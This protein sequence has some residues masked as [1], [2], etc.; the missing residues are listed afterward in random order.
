VFLTFSSSA[1]DNSDDK[2]KRVKASVKWLSASSAE[3]SAGTGRWG[4]AQLRHYTV[5]WREWGEGPHVVLV[6]GLAGGMELLGPVARVLS[7]RF[8]VI[9]YQLRGEDDCFA[10]RRRFDLHDLVED[11]DQF[12]EWHCLERPALFGVSFGG[13]LALEYAARYGSSLSGLAVQGAG[14]WFERGLLQRLAGMV[15]ARYPLP[16]DNPFVNQFFNL[17]F[18]GPQQPGPLFEFVTRQCWQTDQSVMAH[19]FKLVE[20][21][22]I[23]DRLERI[24]VPTL[25]LVG[26][27]DVLVSQRSLSAL[28]E[29]LPH[30]EVV[31]L[32]GA[33]HLAFV[34]QPGRVADEVGR[35]LNTAC[36]LQNAG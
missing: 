26:D 27:K 3:F 29:G 11:L 1:S 28:A 35:F 18:G 31:R 2:E 36:S 32:K 6:P 17:L 30:G 21:F 23:Q 5:A 16:P 19:R 20:Q 12:L 4:C 33:G 13:V 24:E 25:A 8:R 10:M 34:T 15:L 7:Q 14:A 22:N 9:S